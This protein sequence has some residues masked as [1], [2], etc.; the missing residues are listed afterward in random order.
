MISI[1]EVRAFLGGP[2][3]NEARVAVLSAAVVADFERATGVKWS[4]REDEI[5]EFMLEEQ[6]DEIHI[7]AYEPTISKVEVWENDPADAVELEE[8]EFVL[9][10]FSLTRHSV[11]RLNDYFTRYVRVTYD[12]GLEALSS[13][14]SLADIRLALLTEVQ[15]RLARDTD[16]LIHIASQGFQGGSTSFKSSL[17]HDA[18][19]AA[20]QRWARRL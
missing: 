12:C 18:F 9:R 5:E 2:V 15:F 17:H 13:V 14:Q 20:A 7:F 11:R 10:K 16:S 6:Q 19:K 3:K 1:A 4:V 8:S